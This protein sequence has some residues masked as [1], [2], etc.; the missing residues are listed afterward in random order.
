MK[1]RREEEGGRKEERKKEIK[2]KYINLNSSYP[3]IQICSSVHSPA[4]GKA[5]LLSWLPALDIFNTFFL[6][7][8]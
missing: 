7:H 6:L 2:T 4:V 8:T 3:I 5:L 1:E